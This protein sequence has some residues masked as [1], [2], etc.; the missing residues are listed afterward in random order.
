MMKTSFL[1][2]RIVVEKVFSEINGE[3]TVVRDITYGT[4]IRGGGLP[5]SG[6]LAEIIWK[7]TL[8]RV[9]DERVKAC[10]IVGLGGGSIAKLV[11]K[12][13]PEAKITGVD[14]DPI[15]VDLGKKYL[16]L[17]KSNVD[18]HIKDAEDFIKEEVKNNKKYSLV[19]FDTYVQADFPGKFE[20]VQLIKLVKKLLSKDG[21]AIFNRLF[22]PKDRDTAIKFEKILEKV[23]NKVN[24][25]YPEANIMFLCTN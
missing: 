12:H 24:R 9:K 10:L 11:R 3:L 15:I 16:K 14:I 22:G 18:I 25:L 8:S 17:E 23:F 19:C 5:Q 20:S 7:S 4:H 1:E 13:W 21:I 2:G 6:G